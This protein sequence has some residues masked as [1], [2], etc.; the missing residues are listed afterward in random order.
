MVSVFKTLKPTSSVAAVF[1]SLLLSMSTTA[2]AA[3]HV[4]EKLEP[5]NEKYQQA[6]P[7]Q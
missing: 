5:R 7:D 1:A 6:H 3:D 4:T 2:F